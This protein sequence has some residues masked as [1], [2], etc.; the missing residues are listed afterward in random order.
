MLPALH[1]L[2][3]TDVLVGASRN[4]S[5]GRCL[6]NSVVSLCVHDLAHD[7]SS[8]WTVSITGWAELVAD[9]VEFSMGATDDVSQVVVRISTE[10]ITGREILG[11]A[12][13]AERSQDCSTNLPR[14]DPVTNVVHHGVEVY[15]IAQSVK[16]IVASSAWLTKRT[17]SSLV[18]FGTR[19]SVQ[20]S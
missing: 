19:N 5:L 14:S 17:R 6:P 16:V 2:R 20:V 4:G 15:L 11:A 13:T 18:P 9:A 12:R 7:L 10:H 3:G 8:G 1:V